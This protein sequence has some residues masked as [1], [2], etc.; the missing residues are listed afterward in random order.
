MNL[1]VPS[2]YESGEER[3]QLRG[4]RRRSVRR[5]Y[6][7]YVLQF[8]VQFYNTGIL[9]YQNSPEAVSYDDFFS[10]NFWVGGV[11]NFP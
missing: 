2:W 5:D 11:K 6:G 4:T 7:N 9:Q 1:Q 10:R 3:Y 8:L